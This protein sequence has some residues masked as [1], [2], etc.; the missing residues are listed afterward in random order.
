MMPE[1]S[2]RSHAS[3]EGP[4][5]QG[6]A[7]RRFTL[8]SGHVSTVSTTPV[9][10]AD[11]GSNSEQGTDSAGQRTVSAGTVATGVQR[12]AG[13]GPGSCAAGTAVAAQRDW[14]SLWAAPPP[15][16]CTLKRTLPASPAP[17]TAKKPRKGSAVAVGS[18]P[19]STPDSAPMRHQSSMLGPGVTQIPAP[20]KRG[21]PVGSSNRPKLAASSD[22]PALA[23]SLRSR[24]AAAASP[25]A[26]LSARL[27]KQTPLSPDLALPLFDAAE[28]ADTER[29]E[30]FWISLGRGRTHVRCF[31][32]AVKGALVLCLKDCMQ[33]LDPD[34]ERPDGL[35][36]RLH[37]CCYATAGQGFFGRVFNAQ[38]LI[39]QGLSRNMA[40]A[41]VVAGMLDLYSSKCRAS[42]SGASHIT[43]S[44]LTGMQA[45]VQELHELTKIPV[46]KVA[47]RH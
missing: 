12:E 26:P 23:D 18:D 39:G 37:R 5:V 17:D 38:H 20:K 7:K 6:L 33:A 4:A 16:T 46:S 24:Q 32:T 11:R 2:D 31:R 42:Q 30:G 22:E 10:L 1:C 29:E 15:R 13:A 47:Q 41:E 27:S 8:A 35:Q 25:A 14:G 19:G 40:R 3:G 9:G 34:T 21:R 43:E 44:R 28:P 45:M 36:S